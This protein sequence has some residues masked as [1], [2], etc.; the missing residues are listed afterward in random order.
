MY[1]RNRRVLVDCCARVEER[2]CAVRLSLCQCPH[3]ALHTLCACVQSEQE[4]KHDDPCARSPCGGESRVG[5]SCGC[6]RMH[7]RGRGVDDPSSLCNACAC[8]ACACLPFLSLFR[9]LLH[10]QETRLFSILY[11][12]HCSSKVYRKEQNSIPRL[13]HSVDKDRGAR[14]LL[15]LLMRS[16]L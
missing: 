1:V 7:T 13:R 4:G 8:A 10:T 3:A 9:A 16:K 14:L 15:S 12:I 2:S 5:E 6:L 11:P